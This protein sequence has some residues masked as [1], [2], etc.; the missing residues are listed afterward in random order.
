MCYKYPP[1]D[2]YSLPMNPFLQLPPLDSFGGSAI[3]ARCPSYWDRV[4][5][6]IRIDGQPSKCD[7]CGEVKLRPLCGNYNCPDCHLPQSHIPNTFSK[8]LVS[9]RMTPEEETLSRFFCIRVTSP[10]IWHFTGRLE[11]ERNTTLVNTMLQ[12]FSKL[13]GVYCVSQQNLGARLSILFSAA[14]HLEVL[15]GMQPI[16]SRCI[17]SHAL[18]VLQAA[19]S[20]EQ[21][22]EYLLIAVACLALIAMCSGDYDATHSHFQGIASILKYVNRTKCTLNSM[23][24]F[25]TKSVWNVE[26]ILI[27]C[28][29]SAVIPDELVT[30]DL[31]WVRYIGKGIENCVALEVKLIQFLRQIAMYKNWTERLRERSDGNPQT[32]RD[33]AARGDELERMIN[34]WGV[35]TILPYT[36]EVEGDG[37]DSDRDSQRFLTYPRF[38]FQ[39][40]LQI[41]I[42]LLWYTNILI[43]SFIRDPYPGPDSQ[44]RVAVAIRFCQCIATLSELGGSLALKALTFGLFYT[45]LTFGEGYEKG[46][47]PGRQ[48]V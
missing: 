41:E 24:S 39:S 14:H 47:I 48:R 26:T 32:E 3:Y 2:R 18:H 31:G 22:D 42:H 6:P 12:L 5:K 15:R 40:V 4:W 35:R 25:V 9:S 37:A 7:I 11:T 46:K 13:Q 44:G 45:T 38:C 43:I 1:L 23:V 20:K 33:I 36:T 16:Q 17:L 27:L 10:G 28:G 19:I 29:Y 34:D 21:I 8:M 30:E